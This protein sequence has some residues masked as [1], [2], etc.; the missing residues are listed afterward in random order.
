MVFAGLLH[1]VNAAGS[2]NFKVGI[3]VYRMSL[4]ILEKE[5]LSSSDIHMWL[6]KPELNFTTR[7]FISVAWWPRQG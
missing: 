1:F 5:C 2:C 7:P 6:A 4:A 3:D